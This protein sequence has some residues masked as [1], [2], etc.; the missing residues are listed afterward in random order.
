LATV[1]TPPDW[2]RS[3][4]A[5][6]LPLRAQSGGVYTVAKVSVDA[7]AEDAV[8]AKRKAHARA[9]RRALR[10]VFK[11]LT[12]YSAYDQLPS[13]EG[14][15]VDDMLASYSLRSEQNSAT[16]YLATL[17]FEFNAPAVRDF[18]AGHDIVWSDERAAPVTLLPVFIRDSAVVPGKRNPWYRAWTEL[19]LQHAVTPVNLVASRESLDAETV[20]DVLAGES[21]PFDELKR[22]HE[23]GL[24]V[25]AVAETGDGEQQIALRLYG[26][27]AVG[28][29]AVTQSVRAGEP[30]E[31]ARRAARVSLGILERRWKLTQNIPG[32]GGQ[33]M[34]KHAVALTVEFG[35]LGQWRDIRDRLSGIPGVQER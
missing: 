14:N 28:P 25:L 33:D 11:R 12:P 8:A 35:S 3:G 16:R 4:S 1:Y 29:L 17:D 13:M 31:A 10:T 34:E 15:L 30:V 18:L 6:A 21:A 32:S 9:K 24:L 20:A 23:T 7:T 2:A 5:A 27:D 19:D 26:L 22:E